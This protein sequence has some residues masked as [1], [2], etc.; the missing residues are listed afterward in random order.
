[1]MMSCLFHSGCAMHAFAVSLATARRSCS[2][3][4]LACMAVSVGVIGIAAPCACA[5]GVES[6]EIRPYSARSAVRPLPRQP[7]RAHERDAASR[8]VVLSRGDA[9]RLVLADGRIMIETPAVALEGG[10]LG[11]R[12]MVR[13]HDGSN[14]VVGRL[15]AP[16]VV[17]AKEW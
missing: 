17:Q 12:V 3:T 8:Q 13:P 2:G 15:V 10:A 9:V 4:W 1:M 11:E 14:A 7:A 16:G 6:D 5:A